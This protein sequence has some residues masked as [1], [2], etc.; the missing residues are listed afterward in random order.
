M[1]SRPHR[2]EH[3]VEVLEQGGTRTVVMDLQE[4]WLVVFWESAAWDGTSGGRALE[5][6]EPL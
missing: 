2:Y 6:S 5:T 3:E 4:L 1:R